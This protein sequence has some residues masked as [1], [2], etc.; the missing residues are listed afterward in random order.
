ML[1]FIGLGL[2]DV[3]DLTVKGLRIIKNCKEVYLE[4][5]TT[6]L[7]IDQKTLEEHLGIQVIPA[8]RELVE[9]S[10]GK[11]AFSK[12]CTKYDSYLDKILANARD[13]DVAFLVGGD[14]LSATTHTD[15]ILRAV[16]LNIPYKIIHNASIMNAIGSCGL[17]V[18]F[19]FSIFRK[20]K[21]CLY[22]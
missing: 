7:Q 19:V 5:Y 17:Q 2:A 13:D 12:L 4:T 22:F 21:I 3:D 20:Y 16:E 6:I 11:K 15:L 10:A 8:D 9:L 1:Y 18:K 14:P